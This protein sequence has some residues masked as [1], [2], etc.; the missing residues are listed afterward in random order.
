VSSGLLFRCER[1][2]RITDPLGEDK[3]TEP[4]HP[5]TGDLTPTGQVVRNPSPV[6]IA[7]ACLDD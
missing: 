4:K 2:D 5:A 7:F 3:F 6:T 1:E